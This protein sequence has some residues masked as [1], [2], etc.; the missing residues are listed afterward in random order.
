VAAIVQ[1][2]SERAVY[3]IYEVVGAEQHLLPDVFA[4]GGEEHVS[5]LPPFIREVH[6][7]ILQEKVKRCFMIE[8]MFDV[9]RLLV[10]QELNRQGTV[11]AT[12]AA[13]HLTPSAVSQQLAALSRELGCP[14]TEK[15]GRNLRI[16]GAGRVLLAHAAEIVAQ[17]EALQ[18]DLERH[19]HGD[20]GIVHVGAF[21]TA[22]S[23][24][25][26]PAAAELSVTHPRLEVTV[27]QIDAPRSVQE[28]A[29]GRL[30]IA[31]SVEYID[32]PPFSDPRFTR[33]MLLQDKFQAMLPAGH[34]LAGRTRVALG[35]LR[36][37]QW[38]GNIPGSPCHSRLSWWQPGWVS[39]LSRP[40]P[41]R[42]LGPTW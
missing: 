13:L 8:P 19:Q 35:D 31:L 22:A 34:R 16:T 24:I 12:A 42:Q 9:R 20:V 10:L 7:F 4:E 3:E 38:I 40:W 25:V 26:V 21:Q 18:G 33:L 1:F 17:L 39:L 14:V 6:L 15:D 41:S 2:E 23:H 11:N 37:E 32:S 28:V 36:D 30:D 5:N 29:A 27:T